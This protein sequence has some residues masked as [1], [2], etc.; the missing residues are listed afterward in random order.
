MFDWLF[1]DGGKALNQQ[2]DSLRQQQWD[3][4]YNRSL[5]GGVD[6]IMSDPAN[7]ELISQAGGD[8]SNS[9]ND[10]IMGMRASVNR[11]QAGLDE[12]QRAYDQAEKANKYNY[13]GNGLLGA[14]LNPIG[15]TVSAVGDLATG[16]YKDRDVV[17]DIG[18]AG[19]TLLSAIPLLGGLA[20]AGGIAGKLGAGVN[21]AFNSVPGMALTGAGFNAGETLRQGGQDTDMGDIL[22]SAGTGALF[23]AAFPIAGRVGGK[24][25]RNRGSSVLGRELAQSGV[26]DAAA[27]QFMSSVPNKALYQTALK[28]F[29]PKSTLGK[30]AAGGGALLGANQLIGGI[31]GGQQDSTSQLIAQFQQQYGYT[32]S[33]YELQT[34]MSGGY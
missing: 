24:M 14:F 5:A 2:R 3:Q 29:V 18:A 4:Q 32:P 30:V 19:Q 34:L 33:D 26:D 15:Q 23:G 13:F 20:K 22:G 10:Q 6:K 21:K 12:A 1:G 28:S 16:N 9:L 27:K 25:L 31:G 7:A 11:N 17:S 8:F